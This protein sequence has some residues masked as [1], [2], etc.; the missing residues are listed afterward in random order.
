MTLRRAIGLKKDEYFL[1]SKHVS[2]HDV[3]N[4]LES[5]GFSRYALIDIT[6]S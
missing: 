2:K 5:S 4:L 3:M 1:D 6:Y